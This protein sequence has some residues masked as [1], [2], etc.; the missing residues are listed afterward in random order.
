MGAAAAAA[1]CRGS[2]RSSTG[3]RGPSIPL[4]YT[5][6]ATLFKSAPARLL[7]WCIAG[8]ALAQ[9][10]ILGAPAI[11]G[12]SPIFRALLTSFDPHGNAL[13]LAIVIA[14]FFLRRNKAP[15]ALVR[16]AGEHPWPTTA[17]AFVALCAGSLLAYHNQP[18][19]MD[20][21]VPLFQAHA[22][23]TG[24]LHGLFPPPLMDFLVPK[25][26]Q[27]HFFTVSHVSGAVVGQ[28]WPAFGLLLTPFVW[29]GV[30]WAA[31]PAL[32]ALAVPLVHHLA[33]R[34]VGSR[35]AAGWAVL[36]ALAS[37]AIVV[38]S[39]SYYSM[40]A[41]LVCNGLFVL[42]LLTPSPVRALLAGVIGSVALT[43]HNPVP[44]MLFAVAF[45]AR[46]AWRRELVSLVAL[47]AGYA[48]LCALLGAGWYQYL[49]TFA[50]EVKERGGHVFASGS[51]VGSAP[52]ILADFLRVPDLRIVYS[53]IAGLAKLWTWASAGLL[54]LA[55]MGLRDANAQVRVLAW[56]FAIT[57]F[58]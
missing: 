5:P 28:Y 8:T 52:A 40:Q 50:A 29:L 30:P 10:V 48:P 32:G 34:L 36:L 31:N 21:Y 27:G 57:F 16:L 22:F 41:N 14:A 35:E 2:D 49:G 25:F 23:A 1:R 19:S 38:Q 44:H 17:I 45:I 54:V 18:L 47:A 26:F 33:L 6:P 56:A 13:L 51:A 43:L 37:P 20:E 55:A 9:A 58:G 4:G 12:L 3:S 42:L 53:R 11:S 46:L 39:I 24:S 7:L 15:L